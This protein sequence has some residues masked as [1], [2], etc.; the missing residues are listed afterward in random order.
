MYNGFYV[1]CLCDGFYVNC[2]FLKLFFS[3]KRDYGND[4]LYTNYCFWCEKVLQKYFLD[5]EYDEPIQDCKKSKSMI[6][7]NNEKYS[8]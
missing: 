7:L 4:D 3:M 1:K 6:M 8:W 5:L 2:Y